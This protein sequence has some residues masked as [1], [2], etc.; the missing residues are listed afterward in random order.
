MPSRFRRRGSS[1]YGSTAPRPD[2][3]LAR[4]RA[5]LGRVLLAIGGAILALSCAAPKAG[6]SSPGF[7]SVAAP[8][9]RDREAEA[10][11]LAAKRAVEAAHAPAAARR[12]ASVAGRAIGPL[13]ARSGDTGLV[14]WIAA[15]DSGGG[16]VLRAVATT[17]GGAPASE[18]RDLAPVPQE[19]TSLVVRPAGEPS[20]GWLVA[21]TSLLDRGES[22]T[23]LG[24]APD[25]APSGAPVDLERTTDHIRWAEFVPAPRGIIALWAEET[26]TGDADI[27]SVALD[28]KAKPRG[29][30]VRVA[31]GVD[32]WQAVPAGEGAALALVA[33]GA[34]AGESA[35]K[36][37]KLTWLRLDADGHP[38]GE[39]VVVDPKAIVGGDLDVV[40]VKDQWL[41]AWNDRSGEDVQVALA[42]VDAA[43]HV[44]GPARALDIVGGSSLVALVASDEGAAL[45]W[46]SPRT[47]S[48][49]RRT[50]N[51]ATVSI[52]PTPEAHGAT[53]LDIAS[54]LAPELVAAHPGYG[55]LASMRTC[56]ADTA[57]PGCTG[58]VGPTFLKF[59]ARLGLAQVE[60]LIV[61]GGGAAI[62]TL[63][64]LAWG[65]RCAT[66]GCTA[67]E[68][69]RD[70]PASVF[71][72]DLVDRKSPF[73]P[74]PARSVP[75]GAP[76]VVAVETLASGRPFE[77][78]AADP[79]GDSTV[80]ATLIP[81][82]G[83]DGSIVG[84]DA[85]SRG[86][87]VTLRTL[88]RD[89]RIRGP[90][91]T[92][93]ERALAVGGVALATSPRPEDGAVVAW[94]GR[95]A[96]DPQVHLAH[97]DRRGHRNNE[98]Q[99]TTAKG[100]A[101]SVALAW[102][103]DG[104]LVAWVDARDG[105]G[106]VYATKVDRD[107]VRVGREERITNAP[108]DASDVALARSGDIAWVA[109][110]DPRDNPRE[111]LSDIYTAVL[112]TH[113][114]KRVGDEV[115]VLET[116]TNS[117]SPQ[118]VAL[119]A[120]EGAALAW[121]EEAPAALEGP[122]AAFVAR[123]GR[124]G[125]VVGIPAELP[126]VS[127][128]RPTSVVLAQ[129]ARGDTEVRA[130][131]A[132]SI[133]DSVQIDAVRVGLDGAPLGVP[134]SLLDLDAPPTFEVALACSGDAVFFIDIGDSPSDH[135][136]RRAEVSWPR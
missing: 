83:G 20:A 38:A 132:R 55:L 92:L 103:D 89:G 39:A 21:W 122:G 121:I 126:L 113:D 2:G 130:L 80:V 42:T 95:D 16:R 52:D 40:A 98:V 35:R 70:S 66:G 99:L 34:P 72:L 48:R 119:G 86:A 28:A 23:A 30:P 46:E 43:G 74:P 15:A 49:P 45:A 77:D 31:R 19:A 97:L 47:R 65:L 124:D 91:A 25:G 100:D 114:A 125:R 87:T 5:V 106:E 59:D 27:L 120:G 107:L 110:S 128:G 105:N 51:L 96:H 44:H 54:D 116:T 79:L 53:S 32:R 4:P 63:P 82:G 133:A 22:L 24:L 9:R 75:A 1:P 112:R 12:V 41:L 61:P 11:E 90:A 131:V 60:P 123:I 135:R 136:V 29:M 108:G 111:G 13:V 129:P 117:R 93:T 3:E 71:A 88:D 102:V 118:L 81:A 57:T 73:V 104:W 134:Y 18:V 115:R 62:G 69:T 109:W 84:N 127:D 26:L 7:E 37:S 6:L 67:L 64:S 50:L 8:P 58:T 78:V 94:V 101:S 33:G 56:S 68:A 76:R 17:A 14:A 10:R 85:R 36:V